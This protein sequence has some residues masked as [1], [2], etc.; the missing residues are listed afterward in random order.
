MI[1]GRKKNTGCPIIGFDNNGNPINDPKCPVKGTSEV[2]DE[3]N[4]IFREH[5]PL[6]ETTINNKNDR[7]LSFSHIY[8]VSKPSNNSQLFKP[9]RIYRQGFEFLEPIEKPPGFQVGLN[10]ISFQNKPET[11][12][13]I[14]T[15]QQ[16]FGKSNTNPYKNIKGLET[17]NSVRAAGFFLIPPFN[18]NELFPGSVI[19][20]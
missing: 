12:I 3:G 8:K 20:L 7:A 19:F 11:L 2:I 17:F 4:E 10:F 16:W 14:L 5:R 9:L 1:I 13:K 15:L 6:N 18:Q